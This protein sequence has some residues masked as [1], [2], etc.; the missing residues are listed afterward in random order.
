MRRRKLLWAISIIAMLTLFSFYINV[1]YYIT[2]PGSAISLEPMVQVEKGYHHEKG[3]LK[4]TTVRMG[5]ATLAGYLYAQVDPYTDLVQTS[6]IHSPM[7]SDEEYAKQQLEIMSAS[8]DTAKIV[9][10]ERAGYDVHVQNS[11]AIVMQM[12]PGFPA[13]KVLK[14]GDVITAVNQTKIA[15]AA[16][17]VNALK[18]KKVNEKVQLTFNRDGKKQ[19]AAIQLKTLPAVV[20]GASPRAGIGIAS[21]ITKRVFSLPKKVNIKS[22]QIGGPSAGLMFTLEIINQLSKENLTKGYQIAG[23]GTIDEDGAVGRIGGIQ[24]KVVAADRDGAE[25]FFAPNDLP[26]EG[27]QS[28]YEEAL[29]MANKIHTKMKIV[30]VKTV[31]DALHYLQ[32]IKEKGTR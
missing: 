30:P 12:L 31:D 7:E 20:K 25:I 16:D 11:G 32:S 27:E 8:Q 1:P 9:A 22:E 4:L 19:E 18:G 26:P 2:Q 24:H 10:F 21:P 23:T 14:I 6:D 5:P 13:E 29:A 3:S 15:T 28:N 17:L